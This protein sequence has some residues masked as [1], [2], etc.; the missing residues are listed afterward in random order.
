MTFEQ[1]PSTLKNPLFFVEIGDPKGT[2]QAVQTTV[3]IG[4]RIT[5]KGTGTND[6]PVQIF[7]DDDAAGIAGVGSVAH[8]V[9]Q[10]YFASDKSALKVIL[11]PVADPG[12]S[13]KAAKTLTFSFSSG[14]ALTTS[15]PLNFL[16]AGQVKTVNLTAGMSLTQIGDAVTLAFGTDE[17]AAAALGSDLPVTCTNTAGACAFTARNA[18]P[19]GNDIRIIL[20]YLGAAGGQA[21]PGNLLVDDSDAYLSGGTGVPDLTAALLALAP[22]SMFTLV[23]PLYSADELLEKKNEFADRWAWDVSSFGGHWTGVCK[24]T[25]GDLVGSAKIDDDLKNDWHGHVAAAPRVPWDGVSLAGAYAGVCTQSLRND[26]SLPCQGLPMS[27]LYPVRENDRLTIPELEILTAAGFATL[28]YDASGVPVISLERSTMLTNS[29]GAPVTG[30][31]AAQVAYTTQYLVEQMRTFCQTEYARCKLVDDG[32][33]VAEGVA[34]VT[35]LIVK[36]DLGNLAVDWEKAGYIESAAQ[37]KAGLIVERN[38]LNRNRLDIFASP[39]LAN[40]LRVMAVR[41]VPQV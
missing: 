4:Q 18:G 30:G 3:I 33:Q 19:L 7:S 13:A 14:V 15:G 29:L 23:D 26:P 10:H 34:A 31:E 1:I 16:V 36:G 21:L 32:A 38:T 41:V 28:A 40:Q 37:F 22:Y 20:N 11:V 6:V 5:G 12:G 27:S 24:E 8:R 17:A 2:G 35:P 25:L 39:D 9:A